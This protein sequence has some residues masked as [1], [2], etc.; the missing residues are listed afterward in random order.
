M[1]DQ[2]VKVCYINRHTVDPLQVELRPL[3][4]LKPAARHAR[5]HSERQIEQVASSIRQFGFTNPIIIDADGT[6]VAGQ[7]RV[8]AARLLGIEDVPTLALAY[9]TPAELK[10]YRLADNKIAANADWDP[11]ILRLDFEELSLLD[12]P[13]DLEVTGFST[14]EI[15][16]VLDAAPAEAKLEETPVLERREVTGVERGDLWLLGPH[17]LLC[18][19]SRDAA[20][21]AQLMDGGIARD[22]VFRSAVQREGG[23]ACRWPWPDEAR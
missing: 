2:R 12:L 6:I 20:S 7:A 11:E 5:R 23:R 18:G 8:E 22:G 15:D 9:L 16:L 13:F 10:A 21:F 17:R 14:T 4:T 19:D 3:A 1:G